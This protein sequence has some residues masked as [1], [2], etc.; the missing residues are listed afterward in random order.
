[1]YRWFVRRQIHR[2][3]AELSAGNWPALLERMAPDVRHSFAGHSPLGGSRQGIAA[4]RAWSDRL[5][6]LLPGLTFEVHTVA[7]DGG[8]FDTRVGVEWTN[9][10]D[11]PGGRTYVNR[12]AHVIRMSKGRITSFSAYLDDIEA[13]DDALAPAPHP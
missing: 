11:L 13:L 7:V 5:Q 10:A 2:A 12:G 8:P 1:V 9:R 3:F 4:V 6:E